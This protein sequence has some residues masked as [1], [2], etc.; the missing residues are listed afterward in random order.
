MSRPSKRWHRDERGASPRPLNQILVGDVRDILR[1]IPD[2]SIDCVVTS[3]PYF[4]LRNYQHPDQI[5]LEAHVDAWVAELRS[6]T[7]ELKRVLAP[8]GCLWLNL[9]DT[10]SRHLSDGARPKGLVLA[11]ERLAIAL[12]ED[13][14][15]IR[16]KVIWAKTNPMPT[17]V[18]DRLSCTYELVYFATKEAKYHFHLDAIRIPHTSNRGPKRTA[19]QA[20]SVPDEWRGPSSGSN[21]GLDRLKAQGL[22]GHPLGKNPGDV[23]N[24]STAGFR[25][26]HHATYPEALVRRPL[27][28][29]CP[30]QVCTTCGRPSRQPPV[31]AIGELAVTGEFRPTCSCRAPMRP[32]IVLDPFMGS[33]TTAVVAEQLGLDWIGVEINEEIADMARKRTEAARLAR[34]AAARR[35]A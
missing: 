4:R 12:V 7:Q 23:W 35:A 8:T 22:A 34:P 13:G 10:Y 31:R 1:S 26:N 5:G 27:L 25:G 30:R 14:W 24:L 3:P 9:G 17:S 21:T 29:T 28:A 19:R 20:W 32:G 15:I 11:P 2:S 18:R 6:V 33:G 16:N